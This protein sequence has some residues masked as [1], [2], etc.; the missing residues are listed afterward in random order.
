VRS[1]MDDG[2]VRVIRGVTTYEEVLRVA[3]GSMD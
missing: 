3:G 2:M 1:L